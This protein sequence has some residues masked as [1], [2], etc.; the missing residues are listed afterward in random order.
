MEKIASETLL[1]PTSYTHPVKA[2]PSLC[3]R[4]ELGAQNDLIFPS[5]EMSSFDLGGKRWDVF[6][7]PILFHLGKNFAVSISEIGD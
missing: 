3:L 5:I 2:A 7:K 1:K 4:V 6:L